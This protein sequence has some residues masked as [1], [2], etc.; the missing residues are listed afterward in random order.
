MYIELETLLVYSVFWDE[1][2]QKNWKER[3]GAEDAVV[4]PTGAQQVIFFV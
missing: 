4:R 3:E 1:G 2:F